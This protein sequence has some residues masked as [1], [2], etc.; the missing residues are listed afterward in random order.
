MRFE[1]IKNPSP[2]GKSWSEFVNGDLI[3]STNPAYGQILLIR[4]H[5]GL[6]KIRNGDGSPQSKFCHTDDLQ[7]SSGLKSCVLVEDENVVFG[8]PQ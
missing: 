8:P 5:L 3:R 6:F 4:C 1:K 7:D 2:L